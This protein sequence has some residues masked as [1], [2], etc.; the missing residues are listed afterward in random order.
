[1][2]CIPMVIQVGQPMPKSAS[3][4]ERPFGIGIFVEGG[5]SLMLLLS[6]VAGG[7]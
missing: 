2:A 1:M 7:R 5:G 3:R 4:N 6:F